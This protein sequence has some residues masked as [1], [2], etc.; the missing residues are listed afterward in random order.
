M[1]NSARRAFAQVA[2]DQPAQ[3]PAPKG[4]A[5]ILTYPQKSD[6]PIPGYIEP[7]PEGD[8]WAHPLRK[9][10]PFLNINLI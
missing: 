4:P 8:G 3:K 7:A 6:A 10:V 1:T 5:K 2:P 9:P